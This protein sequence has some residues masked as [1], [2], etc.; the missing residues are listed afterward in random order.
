[1][2]HLD[3]AADLVDVESDYRDS[4]D[5]IEAHIEGNSVS[6][7]AYPGGANQ[8]MNDPSVAAKYYTSARGVVGVVNP[9]NKINY[10][11][12]NSV[13]GLI[14]FNNPATPW[15]DIN[16]LLVP[17]GAQQ[18]NYRGWYCTHFHHVSPA[19]RLKLRES[20]D[21]IKS[22]EADF[23]VG[24]F[25]AVTHYGQERDTATLSMGEV[26]ESSIHFTLTDLMDDVLFHYPLT[27]K[28]RVPD[29][30]TSVSAK[31]LEQDLSARIIEHDGSNY[32]LVQVIP[33]RG[34]VVLKTTAL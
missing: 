15:N 3:G 10:M 33:D 2:T 5:A 23:W 12:T 17:G 32:A 11:L 6:T 20:F 18:G 29:H 22:H 1:V 8:K 30:W 27:V 34:E 14:N 21:F 7:L 9:A 31:Q 26:F 25:S 16:H 19:A 28:I 13:S 4:K 24:S